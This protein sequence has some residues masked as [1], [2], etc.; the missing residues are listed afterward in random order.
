MKDVRKLRCCFTFSLLWFP[1]S[2]QDV[3][4]SL[5]PYLG[6]QPKALFFAPFRSVGVDGMSSSRKNT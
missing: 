3:I 5:M 2:F 6:L 4:T 1:P